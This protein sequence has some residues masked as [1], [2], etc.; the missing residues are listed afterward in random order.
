[1]SNFYSL[2]PTTS[3]SGMAATATEMAPPPTPTSLATRG[4]SSTST[5]SVSFS[6]GSA[7]GSKRDSR[8]SKASVGWSRKDWMEAPLPVGVTIGG[9]GMWCFVLFCLLLFRCVCFRSHTQHAINWPN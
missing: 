9:K 6:K 3:A 4:R 2:Y 5:S 1:M 8:D 7:S